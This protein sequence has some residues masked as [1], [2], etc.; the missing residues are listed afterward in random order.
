MTILIGVLCQDGVV[1]GSDSSA[2]FTAGGM[3]TVEQKTDKI[4]IID[5]KVILMGSGPV[6]LEQRF[7][8]II[9]K[10][11]REGN[12]VNKPY[13]EVAKDLC[14]RTKQNFSSTG[15]GLGQFGAL[16]A[17]PSNESNFHLCEFALRDF[18]PEFKRGNKNES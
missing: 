9:E 15:I 16:L 12:F 3:K 2:T 13:Q 17:F 5:D 10:Y 14:I 1:M 4:Q 6:G 18:Q 7:H 8:F 11:Y